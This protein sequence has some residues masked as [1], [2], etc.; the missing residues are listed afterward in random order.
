MWAPVVGAAAPA[1]APSG[2]GRTRTR[3]AQLSR[4]A[5]GRCAEEH[6][7]GVGCSGIASWL[8]PFGSSYLGKPRRSSVS[9]FG[10]TGEE[11]SISL[12]LRVLLRC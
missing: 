10:K 1:L 8:C 11:A 12:L 7:V 2:P 6:G 4:R 5:P 3:V 9:P